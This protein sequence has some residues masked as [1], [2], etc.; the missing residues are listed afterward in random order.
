MLILSHAEERNRE[1]ESSFHVA[2]DPEVLIFH[3]VRASPCSEVS[4][5]AKEARPTRGSSI[6]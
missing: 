3:F 6:Q 2:A 4:S 1:G 5:N